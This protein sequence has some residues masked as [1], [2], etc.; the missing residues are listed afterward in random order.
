MNYKPLQKI[1]IQESTLV[2]I[3]KEMTEQRRRVNVDR[4]IELENLNENWFRKE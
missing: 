1:G 4:V 2:M 3:T